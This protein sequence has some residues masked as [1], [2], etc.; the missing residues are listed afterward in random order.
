[1]ELMK[2]EIESLNFPE[3]VLKKELAPPAQP[4]RSK[5]DLLIRVFPD[6]IYLLQS[7]VWCAS[8]VIGNFFRFVLFCDSTGNFFVYYCIL[9]SAR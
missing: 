5:Y 1:M 6:F 2:N 9:N 4:K 8:V 3:I 7:S